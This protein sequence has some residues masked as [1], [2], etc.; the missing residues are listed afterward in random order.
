MHLIQILL[1]LYD[2]DGKPFGDE[3]FTKVRSELTDRFGGLTAFTRA[4]AQ[5]LWKTEGKTTRDDIVVFEVMAK[6]VDASWWTHYR[7]TLEAMF[8][9]DTIIIRAQ[10]VR[11]L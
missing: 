11:I 8:R 3:P 5:G 6:T 10:S 1:P 4:P 2:N 7:A 9:Q